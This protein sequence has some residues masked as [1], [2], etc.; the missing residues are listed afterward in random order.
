MHWLGFLA[1]YVIFF[2]IKDVIRKR[3]LNRFDN[4]A[5]LSLEFISAFLVFLLVSLIFKIPLTINLY[6]LTFLG[7]GILHG[8]GTVGKINAMNISL[9]KTVILSKYNI[10]FPML[11]GFFFLGESSLLN[12]Y[13][14]SGALKII[15]IVL[16]P[17]SLYLLQKGNKEKDSKTSKVW[18]VGMAQFFIF[19]ASLDFFM[20]LNIKP[21]LI[22][23][24][25]VFQRFSAALITFVAAKINRAKF[26]F[27][28]QLFGISAINGILIGVVSFASLSALTT[29]PLVIYKPLEKMLTMIIIAF[30]GLFVFGEH[31][32]ITERNKWGYL[33]TII[34]V[35][36]LIISEIIDLMG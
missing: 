30:F 29:A 19:H 32:K 2:S 31:K 18:L 27:E 9:S 35:I 26:P 12:V 36:L 3:S 14:F 34:G 33:T 5:V 8:L 28:K 13:S 23:Q 11:L 15:A 4:M 20:K 10:I 16:L 7:I 22:V 17:L 24:A 25:A 6:T 21:D 1:I